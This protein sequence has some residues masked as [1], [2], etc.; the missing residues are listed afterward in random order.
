MITKQ[1]MSESA[2]RIRRLRCGPSGSCERA[3]NGSTS[4]VNALL[5][6]AEDL[7]TFCRVRAAAAMALGACACDGTQ[8][9]NPR[10]RR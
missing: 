7:K 5:Q 9:S 2:R 4:A 10:C 6:C 3:E 1:S 8:R